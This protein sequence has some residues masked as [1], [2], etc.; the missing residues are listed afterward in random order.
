MPFHK[1]PQVIHWMSLLS[2]WNN[3]IISWILT[4]K[5]C[6][7]TQNKCKSPCCVVACFLCLN[8]LSFS[9][10][11]FHFQKG[12]IFYHSYSL[13]KMDTLQRLS[14]LF[15]KFDLNEEFNMFLPLQGKVSTPRDEGNSCSIKQQCCLK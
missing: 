15:S 10:L 7:T 12:Q 4:I 6:L 14:A 9:L 3:T 8:L 2:C 13:D 5:E 11:C 1:S